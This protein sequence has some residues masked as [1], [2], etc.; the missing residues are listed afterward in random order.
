MKC[1]LCD[2]NIE[3][4]EE[5][6]R[7]L[8]KYK[9][10]KNM[11]LEI[12]CFYE[13]QLCL[14]QVKNKKYDI[15]LLDIIMPGISGIEL[16]KIIRNY[17]EDGIILFLTTSDEYYG[18][19]FEVEALQYLIKPV[20]KEELDRAIDRA[21]L[22]LAGLKT[23][24]KEM[25][26]IDT[27]QGIRRLE[28]QKIVFLEAHRHVWSFYMINGEIIQTKNAVLNTKNALEQLGEA[29]FCLCNRGIIVNLHY[30]KFVEYN[31]FIMKSGEKIPI[32]T[33]R[34]TE[35]KNRYV[36]YIME[37]ADNDI[38]NNSYAEK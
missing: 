15:Y 9:I 10:E 28:K 25:I 36:N 33:R 32:S 18:E 4:I 8:N 24:R 22:Y 12:D 27:K 31:I 19:A 13:P 1:L 7:Y 26:V 30:V 3:M 17:H 38:L 5:I 34:L 2:D 23:E 37:K 20:K 11:V 6:C 14:K 21:K 35:V 29:D 16:A